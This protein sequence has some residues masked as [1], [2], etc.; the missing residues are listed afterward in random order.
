MLEER[1]VVDSPM[2]SLKCVGTQIEQELEALLETMKI[3]LSGLANQ[4]LQFYQDR[5]QSGALPGFDEVL[6]L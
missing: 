2:K 1:E 3:G 6:L 5:W 4:T